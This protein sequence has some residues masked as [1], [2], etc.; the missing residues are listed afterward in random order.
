MCDEL[1]G[2]LDVLQRR[3][4]AYTAR[5]APIVSPKIEINS[6][7]PCFTVGQESVGVIGS[8]YSMKL[9]KNRR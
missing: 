6:I 2:Q 3:P 8:N 7:S 5:D 9:E 4:E 1:D